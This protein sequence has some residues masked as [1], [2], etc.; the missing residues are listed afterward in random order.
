[1][2]PFNGNLTRSDGA[3]PI[4]K[5]PV[6]LV[7]RRVEDLLARMTLEEKIGQ[8][9]QVEKNSL[10]PEIVRRFFIGSVLSGGGGYPGENTPAGWVKMFTAFQESALQTR[11]GIPILY[12][13][14]A[15][16]GH[17]NLC[18]AVIYPHN[19]GLGAAGD[20]DLIYRIGRATAEELV[21]TGVKWNFAPTV[22]VPLDIRWG[23]TYEGFSQ[24]SQLVVQLATAYVR[25]LQ[26]ENLCSDLSVLATPKHFVG[27]GGAAWG[28]STTIFPALAEH[29][30]EQPR[31]L[32]ID[33]GDTG[34][35]EETLRAV[36]LM[37]YIAA[38]DAGAVI[39]MA[40]FSSWFGT[41]MHA[42][43]YLLTDV[44]KGELGFTGF[45]ISDWGGIDQIS[46]DYYQAVVI[47]VNA[48][49]DMNMVPYD[50]EPFITSLGRAVEKGDVPQE[51]IDNAVRRILTVKF[52]VGVFEHPFPNPSHLSLVGSG[53]HRALARE[54][55]AKSAVLLKN[56]SGV[57]PLPKSLPMILVAGQGAD[58]IG[59]QC[60]GW[61]IEW[62]GKAG[63]ITPGTSILSAIRAAVS[64]ETRVEYDPNGY[65]AH[66]G[67][68]NGKPIPAETGIVI[69]AELPYA[70][71]YGDRADLTLPEAD[72]GL[73]ERMRTRCQRLVAILLSGRPLIITDQL[74]LIDS[75]IAAWL[76][77][78]EAQGIVDVLFGDLPFTGKLSFTWPRSM[79]QIPIVYPY[80]KGE[81]AEAVF[82]IGYGLRGDE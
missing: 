70:E 7:A 71:G 4:Y 31:Q 66:L 48:G 37:P 15:V 44:L 80:A 55:V 63:N 19:I 28:T 81:G 64:T 45:V 65:F 17:N 46:S 41:K 10:T 32:M 20:A 29:G 82:P 52:K 35:D 12:G 72:I 79:D 30:I 16:H 57:L 73:I 23:R 5:D 22:A 2:N 25:G 14:D 77:G 36:H 47:A 49:I 33:Q 62:L 59:L 34:V 58:D 76:P 3:Q 51:R 78:T 43:R 54:A 56:E 39:V 18:G 21:A 13:V 50:Y 60:G 68:A 61:T 75:L 53:E 6:A 40:S 74:P 42:H 69:L 67:D 11:L 1:M 38:I 26:G 24:D 9:T 8:M 27:D